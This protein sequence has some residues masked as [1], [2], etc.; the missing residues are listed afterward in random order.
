MTA[1]EAKAALCS[2]LGIA[3][4]GWA[5]LVGQIEGRLP[6]T[7]GRKP[8]RY[9]VPTEPGIYDV[10]APDAESGDRMELMPDGRWRFIDEGNPSEP[11]RFIPGGLFTRLPD[12]PQPAG[13]L[14]LPFSR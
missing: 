5:Y 7:T 3:D 4:H 11:L 1:D 10:R 14:E 13:T 12:P 2:H 6:A 9:T 8:W